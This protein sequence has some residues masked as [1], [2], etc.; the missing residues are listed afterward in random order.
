M[1]ASSV[2]LPL[3]F[4]LGMLHAL[5]A[6]HVVAVAGLA[7]RCRSRRAAMA[8]SARWAIGHGLSLWV[9]GAAVLLLGLAVPEDFSAGAERGVAVALVLIGIWVL[10]DLRRSGPHLHFHRHGRVGFHAHLHAHAGAEPGEVR[11]PHAHEH[12][13]VTVGLLHGAAGS[14]PLLALLPLSQ[15]GSPWLG[16][17]YLILFGLGVLTAMVIFGGLFG[18]LLI[19]VAGRGRMLIKSLRL[20]VALSA[21]GLGAHM[22]HAGI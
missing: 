21:I 17:A 4:G 2:V 1:V 18:G 22:L 13:A 19:W 11:A 20:A 6:D 3:A 8:A 10:W 16:L 5:D 15:T 14:A 12:G 9:I 7:A